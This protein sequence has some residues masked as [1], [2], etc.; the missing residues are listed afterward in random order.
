M[1]D[2]GIN[3]RELWFHAVPG[4]VV[5]YSVEKP[6]DKP[7]IPIL[8]VEGI[9]FTKTKRRVD[10]WGRSFATYPPGH[11]WRLLYGFSNGKDDDPDHNVF[12]RGHWH[13]HNRN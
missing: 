12:W 5:T 6:D 2:T 1:I 11:G 4:D 7:A 13:T 3:V 9:E 10:E 8:S